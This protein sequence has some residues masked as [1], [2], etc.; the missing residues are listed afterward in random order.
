MSEAVRS[1]YES[2][3]YPHRNPA[4]EDRRLIEGSPSHL[5]ELNHYLFAGRL[6]ADQRDRPRPF[7]ALVAGGGTGD[8]LIMLAQHCAD[9]GLNA[10]ITYLDMSA[11]ARRI[12][13]ARADRRGLTTIRFVTGSLLDVATLAPGPFDYVDCCGVLHHLDDPLAGLQA[14]TAQVS[15]DGGLGLMVYAPYGRTGVYPMQSALRRLTVGLTDGERVALAKRVVAG[16]PET[17]WLRRNPQVGD[18]RS[19]DAGVYD[20]LLHSRDRAMTVEEVT[21]LV[22]AAG[23]SVT[24]F[25]EPVRYVPETYAQAAQLRG[26]MAELGPTARAAL[27]EELAGNLK[28]H[29]FY[30]VP[31]DRRDTAVARP[32]DAAARPV[33]RDIDGPAFAKT[34]RP[35]QALIVE[36]DGF[37][38]RL[39]LP[40]LAGAMLAKID[41]KMNL[42]ALHTAMVQANPGL[43]W[44]V[45]VRQFTQLFAALNGANKMYLRF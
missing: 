32:D 10:D 19:S 45:F 24:G 15:P 36:F 34:L 28:T 22:E 3:P 21:T 7:R 38:V 23:L 33:L 1:Q 37:T 40:P 41:G 4:D 17:N 9:A 26:R 35:G 39:P 2:Y 20:L 30:A 8:G 6:L 27:A 12:A 31:A 16:L 25:F 11:A 43:S 18:H 29:V 5:D 14:L 44:D 13:E 42:T